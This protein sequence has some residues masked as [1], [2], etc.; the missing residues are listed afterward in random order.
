M[1]HDD[2]DLLYHVVKDLLPS[3]EGFNCASGAHLIKYLGPCVC[4]CVCV[5]LCMFVIMRCEQNIS[6]SYERIL[7]IFFRGAWHG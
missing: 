4:M 5:S 1:T 2:D 3:K 7:I 6:R